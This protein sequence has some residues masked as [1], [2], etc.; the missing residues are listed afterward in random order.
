MHLCE[1]FVV[2]FVFITTSAGNCICFSGKLAR[3]KAQCYHGAE[4]FIMRIA[5]RPRREQEQMSEKQ[6][7]VVI[8]G[9]HKRPGVT[10][11]EDTKSTANGR[12]RSNKNT[13]I[14]EYEEYLEDAVPATETAAPAGAGEEDWQGGVATYNR[15]EISPSSMTVTRKGSVE[16]TLHFEQGKE[17][18]SEYKTPFGAM[19]S[20]IVTTRYAT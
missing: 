19:K 15:V 20:R 10:H 7:T 17:H 8:T 11:I 3:K 12:C 14:I 2:H 1:D 18:V 9:T 16:S 6:V 13:H 4:A 5:P